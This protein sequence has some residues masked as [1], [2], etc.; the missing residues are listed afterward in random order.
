[1]EKYSIKIN[2]KKRLTDEQKQLLWAYISNCVRWSVGDAY[3][4]L[5]EN[6]GLD[7]FKVTAELENCK[8]KQKVVC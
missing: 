6:E 1:M 5:C 2:F 3:M 7:S 4:Q 8:T